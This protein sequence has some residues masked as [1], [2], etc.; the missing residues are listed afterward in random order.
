MVYLSSYIVCGHY[1]Y[2]SKRISYGILEFIKTFMLQVD[3]DLL[4]MVY[5]RVSADLGGE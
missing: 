4:R 1:F 3:C 2:Q 5:S